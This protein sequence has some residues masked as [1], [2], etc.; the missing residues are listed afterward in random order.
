MEIGER[1]PGFTLKASN[2]TNISLED[3]KGKNIVLYFYPKDN[4]PGW[5][6]EANEFGELY[7]EFKDLDTEILGVSPDSIDSHKNFIKK[8]NIPFILLSDIYKEVSKKYGVYKETGLMS[9]MGLGLERSTFII[10]KA[11]RLVKEYRKVQVKG[12]AQDVFDFIKSMK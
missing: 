4:T 11:G 3:Y 5:V 1:A 6:H 10:D 2:D 7:H 9:K 8:R 12:H